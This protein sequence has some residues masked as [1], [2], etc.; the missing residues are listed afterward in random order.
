MNSPGA[1]TTHQPALLS[2]VTEIL[3][4]KA[5]DRCVDAT[6]GDGGHAV[7]L[8]EATAPN[9]TLLAFDADPQAL[10]R[11]A[12]RLE[13]FG[14]R[15]TLVNENFA[16]IEDVVEAQRFH[17][18]SSVLMDLGLS[19]WQLESGERGFSFRDVAP[20]DM[21]LG[22]TQTVTA[23]EIINTFSQVELARILSEFGEEPRARR[24][25]QSI[26]R[27]R[28]IETAQ[29]LASVVEAVIPRRGRRIHPATRT[30]MAIR[31]AVNRELENLESALHQVVRVLAR[32]GRL[33]VIAYHSLEDR[34]VKRFMG[35][36]SKDC[37]CPPQQIP[38][39]CGHK[40]TVKVLTRR[41]V[42]PSDEEIKGNPRVRSARLRAC[43]ALGVSG[44]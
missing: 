36:E 31:I 14:D 40:A 13:P 34:I 9:G 2:E 26:V 10:A 16:N 11:A 37:V 22:P 44:N 8:L 43:E 24:I 18:V 21:R 6:V 28:P 4:L 12:L 27:R 15:V 25:A 42:R 30:F 32:G 17:P 20:L 7:A 23:S 38:C 35:R 3:S 19:S 41:I 33:A 5:G 1:N 29:Q 39:T